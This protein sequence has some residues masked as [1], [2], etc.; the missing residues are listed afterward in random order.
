MKIQVKICMNIFDIYD[1]LNNPY[2]EHSYGYLY[3]HSYE[4]LYEHS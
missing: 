1:H 3:E 2:F 4:Y